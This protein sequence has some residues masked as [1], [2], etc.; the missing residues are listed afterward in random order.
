MYPA[1]GRAGGE[2]SWF[3][4]RMQVALALPAAFPNLSETTL[5]S[6]RQAQGLQTWM[7]RFLEP[8][9]RSLP[10]LSAIAVV[11]LLWPGSRTC[12]RGRT[13]RPRR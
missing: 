11:V 7:L 3:A 10:W 5:D 8:L 12:A 2:T 9:F 13:L 1:N 6:L 4:E